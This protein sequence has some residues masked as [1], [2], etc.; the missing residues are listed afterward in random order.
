MSTSICG[1]CKEPG[2]VMESWSY[3]QGDR[4]PQAGEPRYEKECVYFTDDNCLTAVR[5]VHGPVVAHYVPACWQPVA[6]LFPQ[7]L[8][9]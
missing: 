1:S 6:D 9:E 5:V 3:G 7:E 2:T 8:P 4:I